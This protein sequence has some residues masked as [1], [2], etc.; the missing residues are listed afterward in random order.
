MT[1]RIEAN[2]ALLK[3]L[4]A[5]VITVSKETEGRLQAPDRKGPTA[6]ENGKELKTGYPADK[7]TR[8]DLYA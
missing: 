2:T 7:G 6:L 3:V 1:N 5:S 4:P 8:I